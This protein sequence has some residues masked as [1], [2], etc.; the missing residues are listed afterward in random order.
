VAAKAGPLGTDLNFQFAAAR[1]DTAGIVD[2]STDNFAAWWSVLGAAV[3]H[4]SSSITP[5]LVN[6]YRT[7]K[8]QSIGTG[9]VVVDEGHAY[10]V[11]AK[12]AM[13]EAL[14]HKQF[15]VKLFGRALFLSGMYFASD[16]E[17]DL[18]ISLLPIDWLNSHGIEKIY[19]SSLAPLPSTFERTGRHVVVGFPC[20]KN[21]F[22]S[23]WDVNR[24][25]TCYW[26]ALDSLEDETPRT[27]FRRPLA[28]RYE[29]R[30]P[31]E[32]EPPSLRGMSGCPVL[33][34]LH[35]RIGGR[36]TGVSLYPRG[37]LCEWHKRERAI[38]SERIESV[39]DLI[40]DKRAFWQLVSNS[41]A[42]PF[43]SIVSPEV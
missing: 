13:D 5:L 31:G 39:A 10:L 19:A 37:V 9:F 1:R 22:D 26:I 41:H 43:P 33:E 12:H 34:V 4:S 30:V 7:P 17:S 23:R 6:D 11:S 14:K 38:V 27:G 15:M 24:T 36:K 8:W 40:R 42:L 3:R 16:E 32:P 18:A 21:A 29:H 28:L 25:T 2:V 35:R 20:S